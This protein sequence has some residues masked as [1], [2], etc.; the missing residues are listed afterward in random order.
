MAFVRKKSKVFPWPVEVKRPS[1]TNLGQFETNSFTG[2][3]IRL[4]RTELNNFEE[5][6][7]KTSELSG[8]LINKKD[9]NYLK[10]IK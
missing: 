4:S 10:K 3:F 8:F 7:I 9:Y 6:L 5:N 1:E 2:K